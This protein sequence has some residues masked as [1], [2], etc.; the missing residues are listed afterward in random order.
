MANQQQSKAA[1]LKKDLE[2]IEREEG[3]FKRRLAKELVK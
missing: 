1:T 3:E 2:L